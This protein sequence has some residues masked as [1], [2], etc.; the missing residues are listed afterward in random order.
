MS[1]RLTLEAPAASSTPDRGWAKMGPL[2]P[3][4]TPWGRKKAR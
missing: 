3:V 4:E 2:A 1:E